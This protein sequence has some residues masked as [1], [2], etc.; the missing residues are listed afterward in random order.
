MTLGNFYIVRPDSSFCRIPAVR[1]A[2]WSTVIHRSL[3]LKRPSCNIQPLA[4]RSY[5]HPTVIH[6]SLI[7]SPLH[8]PDE[9]QFAKRSSRNFVWA[10]E[11][12]MNKNC[13]KP[14]LG[15][16]TPWGLVLIY[17]RVSLLSVVVYTRLHGVASK[18]T[19]LFIFTSMGMS[20]LA[21]LAS[22]YTINNIALILIIL[23][24]HP[25]KLLDL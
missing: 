18:S 14:V 16:V 9:W 13:W 2:L 20:N 6:L 24:S 1:R 15:Y 3:T 5:H 23:F 7:S 21:D 17:R 11:V 10:I 22:C 8:H 19:V 4:V 25:C 12:T